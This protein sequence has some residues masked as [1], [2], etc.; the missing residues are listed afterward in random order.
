MIGLI[1]FQISLHVQ[2]NKA[3]QQLLVCY[4]PKGQSRV[5]EVHNLRQ[6]R[7]VEVDVLNTLH[8]L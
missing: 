3:A 4:K 1:F 8:F 5:K 7:Q 2:Y 6:K